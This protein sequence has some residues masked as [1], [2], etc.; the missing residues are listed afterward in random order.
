MK[1]PNSSYR[2]GTRGEGL[3]VV[4]ILVAILGAGV[5]WL[6]STKKQSDKEARAFGREMI[7]R[8]AIRHDG[9]FFGN[10]LGPQAKVDYPKPQ[11]D[12]LISKLTELGVPAQPIQI[13]ANITFESQFFSP[14]GYF[15]AH[16]NYPSQPATMELAI[17]HPVGK[18]QVDNL[19]MTWSRTR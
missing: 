8:L 12:Y 19:T 2:N 15:T 9:A 4:I 5:W 10:N 3:V 17:S 1:Q 6:F 16:L 18:W 11:Q 14:K 7:E 13:D